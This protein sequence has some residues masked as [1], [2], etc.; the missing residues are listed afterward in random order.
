MFIVKL[1]LIATLWDGCPGYYLLNPRVEQGPNAFTGSVI[2]PSGGTYTMNMYTGFNW[3]PTSWVQFFGTATMTHAYPSGLTYFSMPV[4]QFGGTRAGLKFSLQSK[5][6]AMGFMG[7]V[8]IGLGST[9]LTGGNAWDNYY[10]VGGGG[11]TMDIKFGFFSLM[12][13]GG[14]GY[15]MPSTAYSEPISGGLGLILGSNKFHFSVEVLQFMDSNFN[16]G[17]MTAGGGI[18][19][20]LPGL[21]FRLGG[22]YNV[23]SGTYGGVFQVITPTGEVVGLAPRPKGY[24]IVKGTILDGETTEPIKASLVYPKPYSEVETDE[25]GNFEL[26]LP[27]GKQIIKITIPGYKELTKVIEV[28]PNATTRVDL[29]LYPAPGLER[30]EE[31]PS[32]EEEYYPEEEEYYPEEEE[33][34]PEEEE[35]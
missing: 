23:N 6:F 28:K 35:Y 29:M 14:Y 18:N 12:L 1:L 10:M 7:V 22:I 11:L 4:D 20:G 8:G 27:A 25:M 24:G 5:H 17:E 30:Y 2:V 34:Y 9:S 26:K 31:L 19:F 32:G 21:T 13:G 3:A 33:Y 15:W 16:M